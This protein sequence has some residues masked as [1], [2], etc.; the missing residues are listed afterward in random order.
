MSTKDNLCG[1]KAWAELSC[2]GEIGEL[3]TKMTTYTDK[4]VKPERGRFVQFDH[5]SFVVGN[6]KQAAT[7]YCVH[8]GFRPLAYKGLETGSREVVCHVVQQNHI[9]FE[10]QSQLNPIRN[11]MSDHLI[12]HG[13]GVK[14]VGFEVEDIDYIVAQAKQRGGKILQEVR[15][16][17]DQFGS[18]K[19][20][21]VQTYGDTVHKLVDRQNYK[22]VFLPGYKQSE[23]KV[24][25]I[26][27]GSSFDSFG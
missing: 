9:I 3:R 18:V 22:G 23:L 25:D 15:E 21:I 2:Q 14:V 10:F 4:G 13:D 24:S 17:S 5:V 27:L 12:M 16:E 6:A 26:K 1:I 8:M 19:T 7:Y 11:E 20:A